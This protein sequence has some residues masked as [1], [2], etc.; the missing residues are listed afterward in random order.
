MDKETAEIAAENRAAWAGKR[1]WC[2][3]EEADG[4]YVHSHAPDGVS[5]SSRY[6]TKREAVARL[7]QLLHIGPVAPQTHPE[8]A[9]ISTVE[10]G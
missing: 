5:P 4:Y 1:L 8:K 10:N 7:M 3:V 6:G 2:V 9:V